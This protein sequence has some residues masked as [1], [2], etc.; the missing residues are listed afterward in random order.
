MHDWL[1]LV[2]LPAHER[3]EVDIAAV[4]LAC[5]TGLPGLKPLNLDQCMY[6]LG[7]W[8]EQTRRFTERVLPMF[9]SG[10]CDYPH[11]EPRFRMQAMITYLQRDLGLRYRFDKRSDDA[12]LKPEDSFLNGIFEGKGGT[13]GSLPVLYVAVG[14]RLGYPLKLATTRCH[15]YIRWEG[16]LGGECFNIEAS[17]DGVSFFPDEYYRTGRYATPEPTIQLCGYLKSLSPTEELASFLVQRGECW[18]Q[19]KR[20]HEAVLSFAWATELDPRRRQHLF[21]TCQAIDKGTEYFRSLMPPCHFPVLDI[22]IPPWQF[23]HLP[24]EVERRI[25]SLR[26]MEGLLQD[27]ELEERWWGPLRR[28]PYDRPQGLPERLY[29][30]FRWNLP[31]RPAVQNT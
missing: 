2:R 19:E 23:T 8:A 31:P 26:I 28:N 29:A 10:R 15:L 12:R 21:L 11:S 27:P 25:I 17:G 13:C 18:M 24:R 5:A 22:G 16:A 6:L 9:Y 7:S 14:R 20:Y 1:Q 30:N 4:N 3:A